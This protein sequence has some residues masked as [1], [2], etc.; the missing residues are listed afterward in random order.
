MLVVSEP[1]ATE[2]IGRRIIETPEDL[3]RTE[4]RDAA[5]GFVAYV[6]VG[7]IAKGEALVAGAAGKTTACGICHGVDLKGLGPVPGLAGRSPSYIVR[8]L[9]DIQHGVRN[10]AW[11]E[12]MKSVVAQLT[13]E[14]MVAIAAYTAS[15]AP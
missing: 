15:R 4:L 9:Y 6:P 14:D 5:S 12:L 2:S 13:E 11:T 8:Q 3:E 7:S 1:G 10:G